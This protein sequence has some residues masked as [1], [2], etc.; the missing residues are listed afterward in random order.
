M[1][2]TILFYTFLI[3]VG[4]Q[5]FYY[6]FLFGAFSF[7]KTTAINKSNLPVSI[8]IAAKNEAENL[9]ENLPLILNQEYPNFEVILINDASADTSLE[10]I[11][12]LQQQHTHL[13]AIHLTKT[14]SYTGNKKNAV[15]K[16]IEVASYEY[17]LFTDAD[18]KPISNHWI[19]E[20]MSHFT[21][22][23]SVVLGYGA[24]QKINNSFLNKLVRYETLLT[25]IQYFSYAKIGIPYMGVGRNLAYKKA[26]FY[27][28]NG[29]ESHEH[30]KSGDDDLF[31]N[32]IATKQNTAICSAKESH[33]LSV[34]KTN[35]NSWF[36]Q[37]RRH[38][39]TAT[40]YKPIHQLLLGVFFVS[41]FLFWLLAIILLIL[42]FKWQF[43]TILIGIRLI[44]QYCILRNSVAKL[45]EKDLL[46][47]APLLDFLLVNIQIA[48]FF[49][50]S[51]S[52]P[53]HWS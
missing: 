21:D 9:K 49:T 52:K 20:M 19:S 18:C 15:T 46:L 17:V 25:A 43:V 41:Q 48:L 6:V 1:L 8:I 28:V 11:R 12:T 31:I 22:E 5:L 23:K 39:S 7:T 29:F 37:K 26:L 44:V 2:L 13:K 34:P 3:A 33:T 24:Y 53:K 32:E 36:Q 35:F 38:V 14:D 51:I 42:A 16:G 10:I 50:N 47:Y 45:N 30:I 27:R 40:S 4:I